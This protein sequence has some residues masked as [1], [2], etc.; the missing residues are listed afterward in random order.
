MTTFLQS[1]DLGTS[2]HLCLFEVHR[3]CPLLVRSLQQTCSLVSLLFLMR[4]T[5]FSFKLCHNSYLPLSYFSKSPVSFFL[6]FESFASSST[7]DLTTPTS[8]GGRIN[9]GRQL[10]TELVNIFK[11]KGSSKR[12][13]ISL[14][15]GEEFLRWVGRADT[16]CLEHVVAV[17]KKKRKSRRFQKFESLFAAT[18]DSLLRKAVR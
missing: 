8:L 5:C 10:H 11:S 18:E 3:L 7:A 15:N 13:Q 6:V 4:A 17:L 1:F 16:A 9:A 14:L 2:L 12:F